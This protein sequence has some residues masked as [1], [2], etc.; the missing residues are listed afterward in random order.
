MSPSPS[1]FN[2]GL[3][4]DQ[5]RIAFK[6]SISVTCSD[7]LDHVGD[8]EHELVLDGRHPGV[9]VELQDGP[10]AEE[11]K[12]A[13][14][15]REDGQPVSLKVELPQALELPDLLRD[16]HQLIV[17]DRE[18]PQVLQVPDLRVQMLKLVVAQVKCPEKYLDQE[19]FEENELQ[20]R[21]ADLDLQT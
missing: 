10:G 20:Y 21:L 15:G 13:E 8:A 9:V 11:I 18:D 4:L 6:I 17:T 16:V 7:V 2:F 1:G 12:A 14:A 3:E 5:F 19:N